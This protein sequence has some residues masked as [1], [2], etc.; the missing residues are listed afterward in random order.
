MIC[1]TL[2]LILSR[3]EQLT[4]YELAETVDVGSEKPIVN[5]LFIP[6]MMLFFSTD[7]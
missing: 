4:D 7:V 6:L 3:V 5:I 1:S 2:E